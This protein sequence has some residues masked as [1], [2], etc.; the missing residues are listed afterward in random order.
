MKRQLSELD[1]TPAPGYDPSDGMETID[2]LKAFVRFLYATIQE[3][4]QEIHHLR[5][6]LLEIKDELKAANRRA[7]EESAA[8]RK[9][10]ERLERF[11]DDQKSSDEEKRRL[12][13]KVE[14][15]ENRLSLANQT[16]YG[17]SKTC[18]DKYSSKK[19]E[20]INDGR[21]DFDGTMQSLPEG[22]PGPAGKADKPEAGRKA[23][24]KI[25]QGGCTG[26][27]TQE[28][29]NRQTCY[30][31]PSRKGCTYV[32]EVIG[33]PIPHKCVVPEGCKVIKVK[34]PRKVRTLVQRLEEHHFQRLLIEYPD[35]T[36]KIITAPSDEEGKEILEELVPGTGITATLL[37]FIPNRS[38]GFLCVVRQREIL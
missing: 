30:H 7:D 23:Q 22:T 15:L 17:G 38:L 31:G 34:K 3:K 28:N 11:M 13:R 24:E 18:N 21:D 10:F 4:D 14:T 20:G 5:A 35:G 12:L 19:S 32:K 1:G 26:D 29:P 8:R 2:E 37:S 9:L 16:L 6:D 33:E 36:R 25:E 27:S